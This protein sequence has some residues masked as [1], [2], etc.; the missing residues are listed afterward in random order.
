VHILNTSDGGINPYHSA[1]NVALLALK[2]A[3]I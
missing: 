2:T 1:G 3:A